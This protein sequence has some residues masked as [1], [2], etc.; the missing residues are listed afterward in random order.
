M[1][2]TKRLHKLFLATLVSVLCFVISVSAIENPTMKTA[3]SISYYDSIEE[4]QDEAR[5]N[6]DVNMES[7]PRTILSYEYVNDGSA[8]LKGLTLLPTYSRIS[9]TMVT[10]APGSTVEYVKGVSGTTTKTTSWSVDGKASFPIKIVEAEVKGSYRS[11]ETVTTTSSESWQ[12]KL[13]DP[14]RYTI[15]WYMIG[16][17]YQVFGNCK[18]VTTDINDGKIMSTIMGSVTFPTNEIHMEIVSS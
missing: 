1:F 11:S 15:T 14:G 13:N 16:H 7:Q 3:N 10:V 12:V 6:D 18:M 9:G 8:S 2:V 4:Q 17:K 5:Q